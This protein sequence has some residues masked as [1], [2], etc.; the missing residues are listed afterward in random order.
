MIK[1]PSQ[2]N[3]TLCVSTMLR[4]PGPTR[5]ASNLL[6]FELGTR[7]AISLT[8]VSEPLNEGARLA[9]RDPEPL[10][11]H[12]L[13]TGST[14]ALTPAGVPDGSV[15]QWG[16]WYTQDWRGYIVGTSE[17]PAYEQQFRFNHQVSPKHLARLS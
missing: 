12:S 8:G 6:T 1:V 3:P 7:R 16:R 9:G 10:T 13:R 14:I 11:S 5:T 15:H 2:L 4:A 17:G